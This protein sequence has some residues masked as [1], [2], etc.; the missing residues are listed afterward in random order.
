MSVKKAEIG[1]G[2]WKEKERGKEE[3]DV[4]VDTV[5]RVMIPLA[6][7]FALYVMIGTEG[8]G[9]GFQ[10]GVIFAA[11]LI[12]FGTVFGV[13]RGR[14][15]LP[16]GINAILNSL[17]LYIYAGVGILCIILTMGAVEYLNYGGFPLPVEFALRRGYLVTYAVEVGIG[18]TVATVFASLF[19]DLAWREDVI[20]S[21]EASSAVASARREADARSGAQGGE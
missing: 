19:F 9:G 13:K 8:A 16:E 4:I 5:A 3:R 12:L 21:R 11:T 15:A 18:I 7:L 2:E 10:G 20:E 6:Q 17:G 14:E 1:T